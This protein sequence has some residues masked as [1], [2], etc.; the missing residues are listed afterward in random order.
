M[1]VEQNGVRSVWKFEIP[2]TDEFTLTMPK[3]AQP[4]YVAVQGDKPWLWA[5]V[6]PGAERE[7]RTFYVHGTGHPVTPGADHVG[8]FLLLDGRFVGHVFQPSRTGGH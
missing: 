7:E 3:S 8:S 2:V 4:L 1:T 5:L 6:D